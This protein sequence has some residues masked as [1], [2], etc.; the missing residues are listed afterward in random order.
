MHFDSGTRVAASRTTVLIVTG[1]G[2]V[3][4]SIQ[5][6]VG[7]ALLLGTGES[8]ARNA[9]SR[10]LNC[11]EM[12]CAHRINESTRRVQ[13]LPVPGN[14]TWVHYLGTVGMEHVVTGE[15]AIA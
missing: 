2:R 12:F 9:L 5:G 11:D 13:N 6:V 14:I 4:T 3:D 15:T 1:Y 10:L 8:T 7:C